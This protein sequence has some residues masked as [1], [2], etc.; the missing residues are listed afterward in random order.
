M[1]QAERIAV[2]EKMLKR[3]LTDKE[4]ARLDEIETMYDVARTQF[5]VIH[6]VNNYA[7]DTC[8]RVFDE[9]EKRGLI[10]FKAKFLYKKLD[11]IWH[12]YLFT[13]R[14][15]TEEH[16]YY[17]LQDNFMLT[18]DVVRPYVGGVINAV[19]D[20]LITK[21]VR[22]TQFVAEAETSIQMLKICTHSYKTFF[23]DVKKECGIDFSNDF[24]YANMEE[25]N[26]IFIQ[27]C[28]Y[29]HLVTGYD[30]FKSNM[31]QFAW[32]KMLA[33]IRDDDLMDRQA[34]KAIHLNPVIEEKYNEEL[35]AIENQKMADKVSELSDKFK[36]S[37]LK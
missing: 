17:L 10:K 13:I 26:A 16:V 22:D 20:H 27:L 9:M 19:R 3:K 11:K 24:M 1:E 14:K 12:D 5:I 21:G 4:K 2:Y 25:F 8:I 34:E 28:S 30:V 15:N 23:E 31:V 7:Y 6:R 29:L 33:T 36:V 37:K 32:N 18:T 35:N